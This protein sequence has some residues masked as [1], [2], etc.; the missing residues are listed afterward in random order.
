MLFSKER[1]W[2]NV[3]YRAVEIKMI[4][5]LKITAYPGAKKES[6]MKSANGRLIIHVK[7]EAERGRANGR[8]TEIVRSLYPDKPI[9]LMSGQRSSHKTFALGK[10]R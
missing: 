7:E 10:E 2:Q 1:L 5:Y 8:I 6:V 9:R 4:I 3:P